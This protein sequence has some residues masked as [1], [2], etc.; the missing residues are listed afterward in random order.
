MNSYLFKGIID[1]DGNRKDVEVDAWTIEDGIRVVRAMYKDVRI[2]DD[3][4]I[5]GLKTNVCLN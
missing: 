1:E 2:T 5:Y 4:R 3:F